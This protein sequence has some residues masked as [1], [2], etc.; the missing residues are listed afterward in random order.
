MNTAN[1]LG[2][3]A[4]DLIY[5][6]TYFARNERGEYFMVVSNQDR[7]LFFKHGEQTSVAIALGVDYNAP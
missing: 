5:T 7:A 4:E 6:S 3:H 2:K 1:L